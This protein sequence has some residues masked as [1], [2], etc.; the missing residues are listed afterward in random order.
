MGRH[1]VGVPANGFLQFLYF[2]LRCNNVILIDNVPSC[3]VM[4]KSAD[5]LR[6]KRIRMLNQMLFSF[7]MNVRPKK[8]IRTEILI[9]AFDWSTWTLVQSVF[10]I[11]SLEKRLRTMS[12]PHIRLQYHVMHIY[13]TC[14]CVSFSMNAWFKIQ[15][16]FLLRRIS[17]CTSRGTPRPISMHLIFYSSQFDLNAI[18]RA[19]RFCVK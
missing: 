13:T 15:L 2:I 9:C 12:L 19:S 6:T 3:P 5:V 16:F 18:F 11:Y 10:R 17:D 4:P 14:V 7:H 8:K 1:A